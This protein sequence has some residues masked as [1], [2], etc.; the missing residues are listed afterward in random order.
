MQDA[1]LIAM[2]I[3]IGVF[4]VT[5]I[6]LWRG[7]AEA[8]L[9]MWSGMGALTGVAF[10]AIVSHYFTLKSNESEITS[11]QNQVLYGQVVLKSAVDKAARLEDTLEPLFAS[12]DDKDNAAKSSTADNGWMQGLEPSDSQQITKILESA[13]ANLS[14]IKSLDKTPPKNL[15]SIYWAGFENNPQ[16]LQEEKTRESVEPI[17]AH[18]DN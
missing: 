16:Y 10:G 13:K 2:T 17:E 3:L 7:G 5:I 18:S 4:I 8:A 1:T 6:A 14:E 11:L 12:N 15:D 9:K